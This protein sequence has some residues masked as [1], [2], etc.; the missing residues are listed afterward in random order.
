MKKVIVLAFL[1]LL[2]P[3]VYS[4]NFGTV[5]KNN[6]QIIKGGGSTQFT[7]LLWNLGESSY[8]VNI[9]LK[10]KLAGWDIIV[11]PRDFILE[12][13]PSAEPPY[14]DNDGEY[15]EIPG[16]GLVK[17]ETVRIFVKT[18]NNVEPGKYD[19]VL[20]ARAGNPKEQIAV[21]QERNFKLTV[22]IVEK[23]K[24]PERIYESLKLTGKK[25]TKQVN[26]FKNNITGMITKMPFDSLTAFIIGLIIILTA[27]GI[28]LF[29]SM[30]KRDNIKKHI[31]NHEI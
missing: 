5:P 15:K 26:N 2:I 20:T 22:E 24:L 30:K 7:I 31:I 6:H 4:F 10:T 18:P 25:T 14:D 29:K 23:S 9:E 12:P 17:V 1:F 13:T 21:F 3:I 11:R 8:P 28:V 19:L 27:I 16:K